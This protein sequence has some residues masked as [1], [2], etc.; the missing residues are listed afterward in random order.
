MLDGIYGSEYFEWD[1][2]QMQFRVRSPRLLLIRKRL[3]QNHGSNSRE[4]K[5]MKRMLPRESFMCRE[6]FD[7]ELAALFGNHWIC[8]G[9]D[10]ELAEGR[11]RAFELGNHRGFVVR[12]ETGALRAFHNVCRHRGTQLLNCASGPLKN[13]HVACPYH[14]WTYKTTGELVGAP[15]MLDDP[16]FARGEFGLLRLDVESWNGFVFVRP[17]TGDQTIQQ[18]FAE[19]GP[20]VQNWNLESLVQADEIQYSVRANW[21]ILFQNYSECYHC[22][23]VHPEL[24]QLTPY[25]GAENDLIAGPILG[26]PMKLEN[27]ETISR[28]GKY[29]AAPI[30]G[31]V[32]EQVQQVFYFTIF[33]AMF[34]SLHPD[35]VMVHYLIPKDVNQTEVRCQFLIDPSTDDSQLQ[36]KQASE[37]WDE[38]NRQDWEVCELTQKGVESSAFVPGP[39]SRLESMVQAFDD[40]YRSCLD[41]R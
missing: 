4:S 36:I 23:T 7:W 27:A 20:L 24:N 22:P 15:N 11:Y 16:E 8:I 33:P 31:L 6:R 25:K 17:G 37:F 29:C 28:N 40:H 14:A 3:V 2:P 12:D 5:L 35:Y 41:L 39:Y 18:F 19:L 32:G 34:L 30:R 1:L 26:G 38:V 10:H 9:R 13:N 21:K